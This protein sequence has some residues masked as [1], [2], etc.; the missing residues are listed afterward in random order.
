MEAIV[1]A[2]ATPHADEQPA[3]SLCEKQL[4][5]ITFNGKPLTRQQQRCLES[6]ELSLGLGLPI[7]I[8]VRPAGAV[9]GTQV[10]SLIR[11]GHNSILFLRQHDNRA[12]ALGRRRGVR[13][14]AR[15]RCRRVSL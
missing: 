7:G 12:A 2:I 5:R 14:R 4:R 3:P 13:A 10:G 9:V 11:T 8:I 15:S 6:P 1:L